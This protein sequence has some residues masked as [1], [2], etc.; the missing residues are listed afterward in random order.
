MQKYHG[1]RTWWRKVGYLTASRKQ[2]DLNRPETR[3]I[4][5]RHAPRDQAPCPNGSFSINSLMD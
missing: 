5:Q 2:M 3:Y 4:L 1:R